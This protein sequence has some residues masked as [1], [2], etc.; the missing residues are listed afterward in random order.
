MSMS[1]QINKINKIVKL[2]TS[3]YWGSD[4]ISSIGHVFQSN[5]NR[6]YDRLMT[7]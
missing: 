4:Q 3:R 6:A 2:I 1:I 5:I 7:G